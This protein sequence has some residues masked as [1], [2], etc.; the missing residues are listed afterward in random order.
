MTKPPS[1]KASFKS[2]SAGRMAAV[3]ALFQVEHTGTTASAV[4]LEFLAHRRKDRESGATRF[5]TTFFTKLVEGAWLTHEKT[6]EMIVGALKSGWTLDRI[7]P[8]TRAILRA[9][10]YE[11][12][13]SKTPT[14]VIIDEYLNITRAFFDDTEVGFVNGVLNTLAQRVR[15]VSNQ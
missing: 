10:L 1:P 3:Q 11:I 14:A 9:A 2:R 5:E 7:E 13:E 6:D 8:V 15:V 12:L 4:V